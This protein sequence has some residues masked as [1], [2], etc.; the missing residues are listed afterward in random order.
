MGHIRYLLIAAMGVSL[1]GLVGCASDSGT[2]LADDDDG[3]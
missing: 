2:S 1:I 3:W